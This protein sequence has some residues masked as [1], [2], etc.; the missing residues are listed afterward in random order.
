M[1]VA[2][3]DCA[4]S[5]GKIPQSAHLLE[6][7][8]T[9]KRYN[10]R[11]WTENCISVCSVCHRQLA[12]L[13]PLLTLPSTKYWN[14]AVF[15]CHS[16]EHNLTCL[17]K[18]LKSQ[19]SHLWPGKSSESVQ[20]AMLKACDACAVIAHC[21]DSEDSCGRMHDAVAGDISRLFPTCRGPVRE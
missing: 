3:Y 21:T 18:P 1:K 8:S 9:H 19:L 10:Q 7:K 6:W 2:L 5:V 11:T 4:T 13:R 14:C 20:C 17:W 15:S 12:G 16:T